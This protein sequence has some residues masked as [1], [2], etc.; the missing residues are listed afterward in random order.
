M[1]ALTLQRKLKQINQNSVEYVRWR[2]GKYL[3]SSP[4][5]DIEELQR[6]AEF[7]RISAR[8]LHEV[9]N[10]LSAASLHLEMCDSNAHNALKEVRKNL[11]LLEKYMR[12]ARSQLKNKSCRKSFIVQREARRC[13]LLLR[14]LAQQAD[15]KIV[16]PALPQTLVMQGDA[17]KFN[18]IFANLI[19]NAI[20][21]YTKTDARTKTVNISYKVRGRFLHIN[22]H[23]Y[24]QGISTKDLPHLFKPFYSTKQGLGRGLGIGLALVKR[25]VIE[26]FNGYIYATSTRGKGTTFSVKLMLRQPTTKP[27]HSS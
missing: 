19:A 15:V 7:G 13:L 12:A 23:D 22:V 27:N 26:D 6:F 3:L 14:P 16:A 21:S 17:V 11:S 9:A 5:S 20:D 10:P 2:K 8:F 1:K 4:Y 25:T 18:Q 24:G